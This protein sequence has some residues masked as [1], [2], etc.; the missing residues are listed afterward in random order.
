VINQA[1]QNNVSEYLL[2]EQWNGM[3]L[4]QSHK[5]RMRTL[6]DPQSNCALKSVQLILRAYSVLPFVRRDVS[7][8]HHKGKP[9]HNKVP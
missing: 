1:Q 3:P 9:P 6:Y 4:Q 2:M 7:F 8:A 5:A